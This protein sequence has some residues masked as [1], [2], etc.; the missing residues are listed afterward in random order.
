[1]K[2][3]NLV[4]IFAIFSSCEKD[5]QSQNVINDV[6][7]NIAV[8]QPDGVDLLDPS[9]LNAY[10]KEDIDILIMKNGKLSNVSTPN[11]DYSNNYKIF[12]HENEF[13]L[14]IFALPN[15]KELFVRWRGGTIDTLGYKIE[16]EGNST[17][18]TEVSF[19][20]NIVWDDY[21]TER[22][23]EITKNP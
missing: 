21:S 8:T 4:L 6:S 9:E 3:L 15:E 12:K 2:F 16:F 17:K 23:F 5:D 13:R 11:R 7:I 1:M 19:N 22:F 18:C 14:A 10:K 20:G